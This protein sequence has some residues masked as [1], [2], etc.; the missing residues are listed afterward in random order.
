[1][2]NSHQT[3]LTALLFVAFMA[4][5]TVAMVSAQDRSDSS[6]STTRPAVERK[7]DAA[8][9]LEPPR[10]PSPEEILKEL[11]KQG[12][13]APRPV[14]PPSRPGQTVRKTVDP[15]ALPPNTI[16]PPTPKLFPDGYR[17][18]DR[19]GRLTREG[20]YYTFTFESRSQGTPELPIRLLPNR[21]LE[22]ME[23]VSEGGTKSVVFLISGELTEYHGVNYLLIQKLLTRPNL[24]NLK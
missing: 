20:D 3:R 19:P 9:E 8:P 12:D 1:M 6:S 18:V 13:A 5:A 15:S 10:E 16:A 4:V 24:G 23:I 7:S 2:N 22:D 14:I 17:I 11:S 21:L